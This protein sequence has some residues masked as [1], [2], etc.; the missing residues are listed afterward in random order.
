[1]RAAYGI[2]RILH[3]GYV[4]VEGIFRFPGVSRHRST[5]CLVPGHPL[6]SMESS[7]TLF[8]PVRNMSW[9]RGRWG[10]SRLKEEFPPCIKAVEFP[11]FC[12][13]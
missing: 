10:V 4:L 6:W 5:V 13:P 12:P 3:V 7:F 1:M 2:T 8:S 9:I 11:C